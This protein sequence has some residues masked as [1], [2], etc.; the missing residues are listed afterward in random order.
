MSNTTIDLRK[1]RHEL[2][3]SLAPAPEV[4]QLPAKE[5][6][7][8]ETR[9][10]LPARGPEA[11]E[12]GALLTWE[13]PE[14]IP[15]A[16]GALALLLFGGLLLLGGI[17]AALFKNFVFAI[18]L[19]IAGGLLIAQA[20][21]MPRTVRLAITSRGIR[22]QN[23]LYEFESLASFWIFYDPPLTTELALLSKKTFMPVIRVPLGGT[24]PVPLREILLR[25]LAEKRQE[26]SAIDIIAKRLGF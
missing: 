21:R 1:L 2:K 16:A 12:P 22:I 4:P 25:F 20:F 14:F 11:A 5:P 23:R 13:A 6:R 19:G 24:D 26:E 9:A 10:D 8:L 18:L 15:D 17:G 7:E 3:P